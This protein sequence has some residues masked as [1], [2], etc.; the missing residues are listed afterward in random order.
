MNLDAIYKAAAA[1]AFQDNIDPGNQDQLVGWIRSNCKYDLDNEFF[2][3]LGIGSELA[4]IRARKDG[5]ESEV[6]RAYEFARNKI[7]EKS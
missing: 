6:H 1:K 3:V 7:K 4:D 2:L 5:Y